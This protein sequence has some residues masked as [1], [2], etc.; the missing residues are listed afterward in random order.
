M[1]AFIDLV[2]AP[3]ANLILTVPTSMG[4][5]GWTWGEHLRFTGVLAREYVYSAREACALVRAYSVTVSRLVRPAEA[6][7]F[8]IMARGRVTGMVLCQDEWQWNTWARAY[9]PNDAPW[10]G[11]DTAARRYWEMTGTLIGSQRFEAH[12]DAALAA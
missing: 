1:V 9:V 10:C 4:D 8:R 2:P 12:L 7:R 5:V 11:W 3:T 6:D